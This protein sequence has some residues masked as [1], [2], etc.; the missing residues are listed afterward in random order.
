MPVLWESYSKGLSSGLTPNYIRVYAKGDK[1][2]DN[3]I[4]DA[5]ILGLYKDG[6]AGEVVQE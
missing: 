1:P 3:T 6:V 2:R 4:S 5:R